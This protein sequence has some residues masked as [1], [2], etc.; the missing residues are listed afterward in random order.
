MKANG[1]KTPGLQ[2]HSN[3]VLVG[4]VDAEVLGRK[5]LPDGAVELLLNTAKI[6]KVRAVF[7]AEVARK[8]F[9]TQ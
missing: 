1:T 9:R 6:G 2:L 8:L 4:T 7:S 3:H 5:D